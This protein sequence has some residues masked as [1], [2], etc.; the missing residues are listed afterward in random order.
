MKIAICYDPIKRIWDIFLLKQASLNWNGN[1]KW[2]MEGS[3]IPPKSQLKMNWIQCPNLK[4]WMKYMNRMILQRHCHFRIIWLNMAVSWTNN[5]TIIG[6]RKYYKIEI[7]HI[8]KIN[9]LKKVD[10][11]FMIKWTWQVIVK[12][13]KKICS[14]IQQ[15][16]IS[17]SL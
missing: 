6:T 3:Y 8:K 13:N 1:L 15:N 2:V 7:F 17:I 10:N 11:R 5:R 12:I 4:K 16:Q 9:N 14:A